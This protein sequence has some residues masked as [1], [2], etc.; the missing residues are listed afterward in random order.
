[1][2]D[3]KQISAIIDKLV[4]SMRGVIDGLSPE[5]RKANAGVDPRHQQ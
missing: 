2:T 4:M 1:M 5:A 3:D